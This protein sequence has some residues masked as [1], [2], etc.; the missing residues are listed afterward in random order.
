MNA[1]RRPDLPLWALAVAAAAI[2]L[3]GC[4]SGSASSP[5]VAPA[6]QSGVSVTVHSQPL[7]NPLPADLLGLSL[8]TYSLSRDEFAHTDLAVYMRALGRTGILRIGGNSLDQTFWTSTGEQPPS[9][10]KGTVT[11]AALSALAQAISG[12]GWRVILGVNL[13]HTDPAR[14]ADEARYARRIL[15]PALLAIEIGNE[16]DAYYASEAAYFAE[17]ERYARAIRAAAPG[18]GLAGPDAARDDPRW[19]SGFARRV[20][21][22]PDITMLTYH[23]YPLSVC[24]GQHPTIAELLSAAATRSEEAAANSV[25]AAGRLD[26]VPGVIDETNSAVCWGAQGVSNVY[27]SALWLLDYS[28]LLAQHGVSSVDFQGRIA[29]CKPYIPLCT[30]KGSSRLIARPEFYGLLALKQVGAGR[31]LALSDSDPARLRAYAVQTGPG[32]LSI[33]L[34]DIGAATTVTVRL[35][36]AA[37]RRGRQ[38][39]LATSSPQGMSATS[40]ITLGGGEIGADGVLPPPTYTPVAVTA[41]TATVAVR[42]HTAVILKLG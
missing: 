13:R 25:V 4:S 8:E 29:G 42:A 23:A 41:T 37:N 17:F 10:S 34:D 19:V 12:T 27:A 40:G 21:A 5:V 9:W 18:V 22:H 39:V 35:P 38:T 16:P 15:G 20:L 36:Y 3:A 30:A 1:A 33:V 2:A 32:Q 26:R 14:A 28:M 31:F 7:G 11:P 6:A 24:S